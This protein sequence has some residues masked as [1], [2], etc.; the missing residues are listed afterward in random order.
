MPGYEMN[1]T[2]SD[3]RIYTRSRWIVYNV[4]L[5]LFFFFQAEDGIRYLTVTGVQTC[6][7]PIWFRLEALLHPNLPYG[8]PGLVAKGSFLLKEFTCEACALRDPTV[9]NQV[10]F[11]RALADLEA[12]GFGITNAID[13]DTEKGG[14]TAAVV[15]VRRNTEHRAVFECAEPIAGFPGGT[16]LKFTI[17]QKH[18]S[19]DGHSGE[20]D[21]ESKL[22]CHTL[23]RF[24]LSATTRPAPLK[25]DPL[26]PAQR[27]WL[28]I[29][30]GRRTPEQ[31]RE[32]FNVFRYQDAAFVEVNKTIDEAL[33]R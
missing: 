3:T 29:P 20:L 21:K 31:T 28:A 25:V 8:G 22:D 5:C 12:P 13:G 26:T 15:P 16:R 23:G 19:G 11:R 30:S 7:L 6:A 2:T 18:S 27:Q 1:N 17:Y 33:A 4:P 14:W 10:K 32:L 9:T 24:R